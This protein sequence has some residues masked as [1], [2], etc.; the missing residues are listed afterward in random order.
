MSGRL[1]CVW[2]EDDDRPGY[3]FVGHAMGDGAFSFSKAYI[4]YKQSSCKTHMLPATSW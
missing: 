3:C 2:N 4:L 1:S